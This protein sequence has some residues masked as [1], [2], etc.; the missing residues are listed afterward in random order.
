MRR[1]YLQKNGGHDDNASGAYSDKEKRKFTVS[2]RR[3]RNAEDLTPCRSICQFCHHMI[4]RTCNV[5][6]MMMQI[7]SQYMKNQYDLLH[8]RAILKHLH[9]LPVHILTYKFQY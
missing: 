1:F 7:S 9:F 6:V 8:K 2:T 3:M 5:K 4:E